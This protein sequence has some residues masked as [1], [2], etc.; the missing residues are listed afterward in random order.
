MSCNHISGFSQPASFFYIASVH[1]VTGPH[2]KTD[3]DYDHIA[4]NTITSFRDL[5]NPSAISD[6]YASRTVT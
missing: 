2:P 5:M 4:T 1:I 3:L 6:F